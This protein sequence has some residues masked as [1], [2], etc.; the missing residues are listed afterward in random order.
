MVGGMIGNN[1]CGSSAQA[2]GETVDNVRRL[3][4]RTYDGARMWSGR[5]LAASGRG[6]PRRAAAGPRSTR[7]TAVAAIGRAT[8][9]SLRRR[10][11]PPHA[12]PESTRTTGKVF[13]H[14]EEGLRPHP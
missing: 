11:S 4:V 1:S 10:W 7:P 12:R 14:V 3:K 9:R 8:L 13:A 5:R 2:Y 6:S